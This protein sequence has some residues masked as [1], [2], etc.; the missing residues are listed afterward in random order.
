MSYNKK[1]VNDLRPVVRLAVSGKMRS[2]KDTLVARLVE[3]YGMTRYAFADRLKEVACE[4]FGMPA[5][6][7]NRHLLVELGRKMCE[8]D[9]LVWVNGV[10]GKMPLRQDVAISDMRL[11]Y[12]YHAL[13]AFGFVMVRVACDDNV[14]LERI[15]RFG[16]KVDLALVDDA[17]ETGLDDAEFDY[18]LDGTTYGSLYAQ[19]DRMMQSLEREPFHV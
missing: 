1:V 10:L 14:R 13:K 9:K 8:I 4:L 7:K 17:S 12:E 15:A 2:G 11:K 5:E 6:H 3:R 18:C 19:A 16:S